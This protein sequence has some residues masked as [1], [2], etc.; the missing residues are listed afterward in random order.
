M[1]ITGPENLVLYKEKPAIVRE[2]GTKIMIELLTGKQVNV[3]IK[4]VILLHPGPITDL[5][6]L[7]TEDVDSD[8]LE[9]A[10]EMLYGEETTIQEFAELAF[11]DWTPRTAWEV[12]TLLHDGLYISGTP[13]TITVSTAEAYAEEKER[14]Q[15]KI[16]QQQA[17]SEFI[18]RVKHGKIIEEDTKR[19][20]DVENLAYG[21][22]GSSRILKELGIKEDEEHAHA[23]LLKLGIW[24]EYIDPYI[25]RMGCS[26]DLEHHACDVPG[27]ED[28]VDLTHLQSFAI[29][30]EGNKDPDD[31]IGI[32]GNRIWVHIADVASGVKPGTPAD[33][34][35]AEQGATFYLPEKV[36]PMLHASAVA[37]FGLGLQQVSPALSF[38]VLLGDDGDIINVRICRSNV[39]VTRLTYKQAQE[40][41]RI[42]PLKEINTMMSRY[43][44]HRK[45]AGAI[46]LSLPE[47]KTMVD[48]H[49]IVSI[50]PITRY[51]SRDL[52]SNAM[53]MA[54]E[55]AALFAAE[56]QI[57]FPYTVQVPPE[58]KLPD[59]PTLTEMYAFRRHLRPSEVR[60]SPDVHAGLGV[61]YYS[62][63]TSPLRRYVDLLVHQQLR[64]YLTGEKPMDEQE[65][66]YKASTASER[67]KQIRLLER[68]VNYH[69][70]MVYLMQHRD[71]KG[72]GLVVEIR[73]RDCTILIPSLAMETRMPVIPEI[74]VGEE[75][76]LGIDGVD[77]AYGTVQFLIL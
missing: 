26:L 22:S 32:D 33:K 65:L 28:R 20:F 19:F 47:V 31:A 40:Q 68:K 45:A 56:H 1:E 50:D 51:P 21:K 27:E 70:K 39:C 62:R 42:S 35:A 7:S 2:I 67:A 64:S 5:D 48:E 54:G 63:A 76:N 53:V 10:C 73:K 75:I 34:D 25:S 77:I 11:G 37:F 69:W 4:D 38:G 60:L 52:V 36:V 3:R 17:W 23:L 49:H 9:T 71:W 30:D 16:Q 41:L 74:S 6:R 14:R 18:Q 57:P 44:D 12:V 61:S 58:G 66:L 43:H 29:D 55:A 24:N 15:V 13:W 72:R 59:S 46:E 8:E